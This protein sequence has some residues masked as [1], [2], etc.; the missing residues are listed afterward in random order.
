VVWGPAFL[1][2]LGLM[3]FVARLAYRFVEL[4]SQSFGRRFLAS[5]KPARG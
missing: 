1:L 4:P 2:V 5:G 3:I